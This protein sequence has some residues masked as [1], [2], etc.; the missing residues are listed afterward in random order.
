MSR[1]GLTISIDVNGVQQQ[2]IWDRNCTLFSQSFY[3][4][5]S[6]YEIGCNCNGTIVDELG[7]FNSAL[8]SLNQDTTFRLYESNCAAW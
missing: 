5:A 3:I 1:D 7:I 8:I 4:L 6:G 2:I